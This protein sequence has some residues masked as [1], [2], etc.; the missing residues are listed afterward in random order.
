MYMK[1]VF[2]SNPEPTHPISGSFWVSEE[3]F[4]IL[5]LTGKSKK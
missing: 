5:G 1:V 2:K 4:E 3:N